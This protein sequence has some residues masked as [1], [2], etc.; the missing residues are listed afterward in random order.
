[1]KKKI[2][3]KFQLILNINNN[4]INLFIKTIIAGDRMFDRTR[5]KS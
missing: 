1:M 3:F 5:F 4:L 2:I